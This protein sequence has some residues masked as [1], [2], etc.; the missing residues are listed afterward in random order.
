MNTVHTKPEPDQGKCHFLSPYFKAS[1]PES[2]F[3]LCGKSINTL[4]AEAGTLL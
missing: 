3:S 4:K 2:L 1:A